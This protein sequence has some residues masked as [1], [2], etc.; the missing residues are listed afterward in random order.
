MNNN[1]TTTNKN[2]KQTL[3][4][5]KDLL[6][7][8]NKILQKKKE[9]VKKSN[10]CV[11]CIHMVNDG[12]D[13][14]DIL[15]CIAE[16]TYQL[17]SFTNKQ[18]GTSYVVEPIPKV[19]MDPDTSLMWQVDVN[20]K[21]YTWEEAFEYAKNLNTE[22]YGGYNDW[23]VPNIDELYSIRTFELNKCSNGENY[24]IK[25]PLVESM[26]SFTS[27][28]FWSSTDIEEVSNG[29]WNV[30]FLN[31]YNFANFKAFSYY[32]RCVRNGR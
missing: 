25:K 13:I 11:A 32:V 18:G 19:W 12:N 28:F 23:R 21:G 1:L 4:K 30:E 14:M 7:I 22:K 2:A 31:G 26:S 15:L 29:A 8:T 9:V 16:G 20:G 6:D 3:A 10:N 24:F 17:R 5:T 27:D